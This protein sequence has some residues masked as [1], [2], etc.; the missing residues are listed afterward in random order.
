MTG[1][2]RGG[3]EIVGAETGDGGGENER[4]ERGDG[5]REKGIVVHFCGHNYTPWGDAPFLP[6][7]GLQFLYYFYFYNLCLI[8]CSNTAEPATGW[9]Y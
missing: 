8:H 4:G 9:P 1:K 6:L 5:R 2:G 3:A 7:C